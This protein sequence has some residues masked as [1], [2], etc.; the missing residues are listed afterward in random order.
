MDAIR[1]ADHP[2]NPE[3]SAVALK[4]PRWSWEIREE[5]QWHSERWVYEECSEQCKQILRPKAITMNL[6][7]IL[8]QQIDTCKLPLLRYQQWR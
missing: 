1:I 8:Q 7:D 5:D 4:N 2:S 6:V 3:I